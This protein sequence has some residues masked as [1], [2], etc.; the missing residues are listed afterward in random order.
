MGSFPGS[1]TRTESYGTG[2]SK[3]EES[4][5]KVKVK[6]D[7]CQMGGLPAPGDGISVV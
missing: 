3:T 4:V 5:V 2:C 7:R 1:V 6:T